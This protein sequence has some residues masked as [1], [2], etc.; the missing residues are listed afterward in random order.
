MRTQNPLNG[1]VTLTQFISARCS[2]WRAYASKIILA[3][4]LA[5]A[6]SEP[7]LMSAPLVTGPGL[8]SGYAAYSGYP[9]YS[10]LASSSAYMYTPGYQ[11]DLFIS[12]SLYNYGLPYAYAADYVYRR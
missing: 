11:S 2:M 1:F 5:S 3:C 7:L 9:L 10:P 4:A 6:V 12:P 8:A